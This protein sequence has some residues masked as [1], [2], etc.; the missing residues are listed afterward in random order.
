M[1]EIIDYYQRLPLHIEPIALTIGSFSVGWYSLMYLAA[2]GV[3]YFLLLYRSK[4]DIDRNNGSYLKLKN[5]NK[6]GFSKSEFKD[7][8]GD[9][10]L[11]SF[12]GALIGGRLGY[13]I[14]YNP[15]YYL[16]HLIEIFSPYDFAIGEFTGIYGMSYHGGFIGVAV[17][18]YFF[19]RK[20]KLSFWRWA[21]FVIPAIPAGYFFGRIGNFLNLE[22]YGRAT[23][24]WVGMYFPIASGLQCWR[25]P[26]LLTHRAAAT[27]SRSRSTA[28]ATAPRPYRT[29]TATA[30]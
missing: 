23:D 15:S 21:D 11:V 16:N 30:P 13:V 18:A 6:D 24:S 3:I 8:I 12:V 26:A 17:A 7:L 20:R 29:A 19:C 10:L 2:A 9:F 28:S 4:K 22:L 25:R 27:G 1:R 14:F 5:Q